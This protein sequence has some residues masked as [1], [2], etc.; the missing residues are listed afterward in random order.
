MRCHRK[1]CLCDKLLDGLGLYQSD[2]LT[3]VPSIEFVRIAVA[4]QP[5]LGDGRYCR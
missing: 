5:T 1:T 4:Y 2:L 3:D